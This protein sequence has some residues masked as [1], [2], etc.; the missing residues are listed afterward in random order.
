[1]SVRVTA[2]DLRAGLRMAPTGPGG[3]F[4]LPAP[5]P[6]PLAKRTEAACLCGG[7]LRAAY[8][9]GPTDVR[10]V[11]ELH[12]DEP[13]HRRWAAARFDQWEAPIDRA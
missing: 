3:R 13:R 12:Q 5:E 9:Y 6:T 4:A 7:L 1:M 8:P 11:V 10:A 2:N